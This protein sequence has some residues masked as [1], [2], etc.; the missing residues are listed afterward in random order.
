MRLPLVSR[1]MEK[2]VIQELDMTVL[3]GIYSTIVTEND[4]L[5]T[6]YSCIKH[7]DMGADVQLSTVP[8]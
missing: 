3:K 7:W 8:K 5:K 1:M 2:C 6:Q 4:K